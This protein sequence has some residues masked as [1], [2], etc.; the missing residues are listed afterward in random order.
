MK[1]TLTI[2]SP[3]YN[4]EPVIRDFYAALRKQLDDLP[5]YESTMLFVVDKCTDNTLDVLKDIAQHDPS[6]SI[7]GL[8]SRFGY[9]M[10]LLAGIDHARGDAVITMD[11]DMQNPP[12]VIPLLLAEYEKGAD[13]VYTVRE[14]TEGLGSI[15]KAQS[16]F[17]YWCI[18]KISDVAITENASDFRLITQRVAEVIRTKIRERNVFLRG[19]ITWIGF[20]Q[21]KVFFVA[22]KRAKGRTKFSSGRLVQFALSGLVSFSRKPLRAATIVGILFALFGF[23]FG[24]VTIMQYV[25][26][27]IAQP[28]YATIIV[29]LSIFGGFQ[30][31]FLGIIGEYIGGIFDEVKARPQYLVQEAVN[32]ADSQPE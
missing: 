32:I 11:V 24:I 28:G 26:G 2:A 17:F 4:E 23:V 31:I 3:V 27:K 10:S 1:K 7:L 9:Q 19:I 13:I 12:S 21:S 30:L 6:V 25:L 8:S 18:N 22:P 29:L 20:T 16:K 15:R 5:N 14:N